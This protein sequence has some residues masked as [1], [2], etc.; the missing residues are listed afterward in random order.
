MGFNIMLYSMFYK[1][2]LDKNNDMNASLSRKFLYYECKLLPFDLY[3]NKSIIN[4]NIIE[5][6][7]N[8]EKDDDIENHIND[9]DNKDNKKVDE[10]NNKAK[11]NSENKEINEYKNMIFKTENYELKYNTEDDIYSNEFIIDHIIINNL[12]RLLTTSHPYCSLE[13]LLN[14]YNIRYLLCPIK[15]Q[16]KSESTP[17]E[18]CFTE[19]EKKISNKCYYILY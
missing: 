17:K 16:D 11:S 2:L 15:I 14:I 1:I 4:K 18:L 5:N 13:L 3:L 6:N 8:E 10:S 9:N 7:E 19:E 12:I